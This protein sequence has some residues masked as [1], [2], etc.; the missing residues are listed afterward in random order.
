MRVARDIHVLS[1]ITPL[2]LAPRLKLLGLVRVTLALP[3]LSRTLLLLLC[4]LEALLSMGLSRTFGYT[5]VGAT[6]VCDRGEVLTVGFVA[7]AE[8]ERKGGAGVLNFWLLDSV[9]ANLRCGGFAADGVSTRVEL[10]NIPPPP[11]PPNC[12][13]I[14]GISFKD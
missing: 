2:L 5:G 1:F 4:V 7:G 9:H 11:T 14:L 3:G 10:D 13:D 12:G 6:K 8:I